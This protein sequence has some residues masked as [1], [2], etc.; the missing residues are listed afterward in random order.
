MTNTTTATITAQTLVVAD[1]NEAGLICQTLVEVA[2][3]TSFGEAD[4]ELAFASLGRTGP[5]ELDGENISAPV[6][7]IDNRFNG[8]VAAKLDQAVGATHHAFEVA[9]AN[10]VEDGDLIAD[11]ELQG[12]AV[13]AGSRPMGALFK[14][15]MV[16]EGKTWAD[17]WT[18]DF[19]AMQLVQR[20]RQFD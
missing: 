16:A 4:T 13:V 1:R 11:M 12:I 15:H 10:E 6:Q 7:K 9:F 2:R 14:I 8:T 18:T 3:P 5:W 20:A 17:R 19:P